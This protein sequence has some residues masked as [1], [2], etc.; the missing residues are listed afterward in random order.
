MPLER[1]TLST[2]RTRTKNDLSSVNGADTRLPVGLMEYFAEAL[3]GHAH[4]HFGYLAA[5]AIQR[6]PKYATG[7]YLQDLADWY[8]VPRQFATPATGTITCSGT[9]GTNVPEGTLWQRDDNVQYRVTVTTAIGGGGTASVPVEATTRGNTTNTPASTQLTITSPLANISATATVGSN[10]LLGGS[11]DETEQ[12]WRERIQFEAANPPGPG[13]RDDY[14]RWTRQVPGVTRAWCYPNEG[15][16]GYV[17]VRFLM[18]ED[19]LHPNGVPTPGDVTAVRNSLLTK[20]PVQAQEGLSVL[21]PTTQGVNF[22]IQLVAADTPTIR[23]E[24]EAELRDLLV[25]Q[26]EPGGVLYISQIR[27]AISNAEGEVS[28]NLLAPA[29]NITAARNAIL[30]FGA[31]TW[32]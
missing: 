13:T 16:A 1:P 25:R 7:Q 31:I 28:H 6:F 22:N 26:V 4:E 12:A 5:M 11:N 8:R 10:G 27:Q 23:A 18:Q 20:I 3:A 17:V 15:G 30:V 24:V 32:S 2:L 14:I 9:V 19:S 21:A 29:A